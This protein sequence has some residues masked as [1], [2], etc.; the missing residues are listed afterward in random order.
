MV[1]ETNVSFIEGRI[2]VKTGSSL[3]RGLFKVKSSWVCSHESLVIRLGASEE[4]TCICQ[5]SVTDVTSIFSITVISW[6]VKE[7]RNWLQS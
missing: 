4:F 5:L 6:R 1:A 7:K 3:S 2:F